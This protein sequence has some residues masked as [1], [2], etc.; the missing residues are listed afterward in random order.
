MNGPD[1]SEDWPPPAGDLRSPTPPFWPSDAR[2]DPDLRVPAAGR[3]DPPPTYWSGVFAGFIAGLA[4]LLVL[5]AVAAAFLLPALQQARNAA[6]QPGTATNP[7]AVST[8]PA[9]PTPT[10]SP[11]AAGRL[12]V[13]PTTASGACRKHDFQSITLT[14]TGA[15]ALPWAASSSDSG[16]SVRPANGTLDAGASQT[17]TL[18]GSAPDGTS[19][20]LT[21]T[22]NGGAQTVT[23]TCL[24]GD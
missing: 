4:V 12:S 21:F 19:V 8:K 15:A 13:S 7:L 17:V 1:H 22:S 10:A 3:T 5:A 11:T 2:T 9:T 16:V 20:T 14:N 6:G 18:S 23:Y 24:G